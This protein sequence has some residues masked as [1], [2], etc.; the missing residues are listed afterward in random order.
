LRL[1]LRNVVEHVFCMG[2]LVG[3]A[4]L[5][6]HPIVL[7]DEVPL[8][9][10]ALLEYAPWEPAM[11]PGAG[12]PHDPAAKLQMWRYY[13]W[14][15]FLSDAAARGDSILWNPLE[16]CGIPF[17]ALW[18]SRC[19]SP[20]SLP[21]YFF[22]PDRGLQI[23]VILK[24]IVAGWCAFYAARRLGFRVPFALW[25]GIAF[26]LSAHVFAV[27]GM[28]LSDVTPWLPLLVLF[29]ARL[30]RGQSHH[31]PTGAVTLALMLLGG[32]GGAT[33][34][35]A[36]V[37]AVYIV[38]R[39]LLGSRKA[40]VGRRAV[41]AFGVAAV[42][43]AGLAAPQIVPYLEFLGVAHAPAQWDCSQF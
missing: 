21:F 32:D 8:P 40:R 1:R 38:F 18:E 9:A 10:R 19:L 43:A 28:P 15:V 29:A 39:A 25:V 13:P 36:L 41:A 30:A 16:G 20:F 12:I 33:A 3:V 17:L 22:P 26:Q 5:A 14:Y 4:L 6:F 27:A 35:A 37:A 34:A 2:A 42:L 11:P 7:R 31:W 23:S 24:V